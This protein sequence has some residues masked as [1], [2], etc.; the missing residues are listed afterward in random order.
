[1]GARATA[2]GACNGP[3]RRGLAVQAGGGA[4]D[5]KQ[6]KAFTPPRVGCVGAA[7][8]KQIKAFTPPHGRPSRLHGHCASDERQRIQHARSKARVDGHEPDVA[9]P[10]NLVHT[11][12]AQDLRRLHNTRLHICDVRRVNTT[13]G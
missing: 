4:A 13:C 7:D 3:E 5:K 6:I 1:M 8:N 11:E 2:V 12:G 10:N 9:A